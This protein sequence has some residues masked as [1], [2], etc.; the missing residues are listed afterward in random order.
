MQRQHMDLTPDL[1]LRAYRAGLFPMAETRGNFRLYWL[2]P[3]MR[4]VLP[5]DRFHL[6]R[7]LRR[8]VLADHYRVTTDQ[9]FT[10]VITA[11]AEA[12]QDRPETWINPVIE[13]LF[14][15]L[16]LQGHAH[17]VECWEGETLVGGLYGLAIGGAF[18]GESMFSRARDASKVA[19]VHLVARL[20]LAGFTLLDTQFV[21]Q[22]LSQFGT[23]EVPR[24]LY[25]AQLAAAVDLPVTWPLHPEGNVLR[26]AIEALGK[27][28]S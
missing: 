18:F 24:D 19:L 25:R 27:D 2:D 20:R 11:C 13:R 6:P 4:G 15:A 16:H 23:E 9:D 14:T 10:A 7:R 21:T 26:N 28:F 17:S 8:T 1:L 5:L 12:T 22:H 3:E